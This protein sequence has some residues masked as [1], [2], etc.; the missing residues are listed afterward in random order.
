MWARSALPELLR[1]QVL[2][3]VNRWGQEFRYEHFY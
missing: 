3:L 2:L 1:A